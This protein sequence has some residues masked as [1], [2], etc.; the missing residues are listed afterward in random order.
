MATTPYF[1]PDL[2]RFLRELKAHNNRD[3]FQANKER[4]ERSLRDPFLQL[5]SDLGPRLKAISAQFVADP[6]PV[7]GS[8]MRI[9][10]DTRFSKDKTPY[11]TAV[12]AH[13]GGAAGRRTLLFV[14]H[15]PRTLPPLRRYLKPIVESFEKPGK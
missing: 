14:A 15:D 3:W 7:G 5:V 1:T 6:K 2:F 10:R 13:L 4:Y 8:M 12:M 11:K 9:Y